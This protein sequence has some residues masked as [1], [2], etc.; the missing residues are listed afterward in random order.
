MTIENK[1]SSAVILFNNK[2]ELALQLRA[3]HDD[4]FP[5]HWDFAA[6][7]GIDAGEN[8][9][10]AAEREVR[11]EL[12]VAVSVEFVGQRQ[13]VYPGWKEGV[14]RHIDLWIFKGYCDGP[15]QPDPNEVAAVSFFSEKS[16]AAMKEDGEKFHPEFLLVLGEGIV[17]GH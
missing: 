10:D 7:G 6:G 11:E 4:S 17:F 1:K 5:A 16:I 2:G 13:Y 15:F 8:E 3:A 12:G 9:K 14:V